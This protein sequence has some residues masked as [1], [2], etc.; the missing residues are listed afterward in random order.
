MLP[1]ALDRSSNAAR[2]RNLISKGTDVIKTWG[3]W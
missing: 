1:F 3:S 2:S